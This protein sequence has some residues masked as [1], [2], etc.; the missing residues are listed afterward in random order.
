MSGVPQGS[1]LRLVLFS[2]SMSDNDY[3]IECTLSRFAGNTKLCVVDTL[4]GQDAIQRDP[5]K[6]MQW[7]Q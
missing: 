1:I 3:R 5:D 6:L 4:E 2:I 7:A